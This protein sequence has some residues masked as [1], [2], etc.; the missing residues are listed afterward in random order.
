MSFMKYVEN[1]VQPD[2]TQ[3]KIQRMRIATW[4]PKATSKCLECVIR[5][6]FSLLQ[7]LQENASC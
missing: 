4:I 2:R 7:L 5:I 6:V 3:K 1:I